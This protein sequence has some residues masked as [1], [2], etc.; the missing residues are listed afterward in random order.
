LPIVATRVGSI[1]EIVL[2]G[3]TGFLSDLS[4]K[5]LADSVTKLASSETLRVEMGTKAHNYTMQRYGVERL[6]KD[7]QKLYE[8]LL[9]DRANS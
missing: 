5:S 6:V 3:E 4:P 8:R 7:H 1:D 2:D 9:N